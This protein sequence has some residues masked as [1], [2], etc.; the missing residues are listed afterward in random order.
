M[1]SLAGD[2]HF[3]VVTDAVSEDVDLQEKRR[4]MVRPGKMPHTRP[5]TRVG[6]KVPHCSLFPRG[7]GGG[8]STGL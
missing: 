5:G 3:L 8:F 7:S 6:A 2:L 1:L 4:R